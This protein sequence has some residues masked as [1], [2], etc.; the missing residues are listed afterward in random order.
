[1]EKADILELTVKFLKG[2][3]QQ[4]AQSRAPKPSAPQMC[5]R[6][7]HPVQVPVKPMAVY[8]TGYN[9]AMDQVQRYATTSDLDDATAARL[10]AHLKSRSMT[11]YPRVKRCE[12]PSPRLCRNISKELSTMSPT[13][14][15]YLSPVTESAVTSLNTSF[16]GMTAI[17]ASPV[18]HPVSPAQ[19]SV[20]RPW[21]K[22]VSA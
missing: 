12:V 19:P 7:V 3:Q 8:Q 17:S 18:N 2:M 22:Q 9:Q 15:S 4:N 20:W 5:Q 13:S 1:M 14:R 6:L 10:A 21:E 16:S 11:S